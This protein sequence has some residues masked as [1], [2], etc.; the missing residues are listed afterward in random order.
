MAP[1]CIVM[2]ALMGLA[3]LFAVIFTCICYKKIT[4]LKNDSTEQLPRHVPTS[5]TL[6]RD[7]L[8]TPTYTCN[9]NRNHSRRQDH[10][11]DP[12][13]PNASDPNYTPPPLPPRLQGR[14]SLFNAL[15]PN[16]IMDLPLLYN[17]RVQIVEPGRQV[18]VNTRTI[19]CAVCQELVAPSQPYRVLP[20]SHA[21]HPRYVAFFSFSLL[22]FVLF[23]CL[24]YELLIF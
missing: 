24:F 14:A 20:C 10:N 12:T 11:H 8:S 6:P 22:V 5:T 21:A 3:L 7:S 9:R 17:G 2:L 13:H 19:S 18:V 16:Q 15:T 1:I 4:N 23:W